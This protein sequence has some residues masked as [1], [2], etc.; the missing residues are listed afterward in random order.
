MTLKT[1]RY[2]DKFKKSVGINI[3]MDLRLEL[4][5]IR[6]RKC[7]IKKRITLFKQRRKGEKK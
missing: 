6:L 2:R 7:V 4:I 5:I 1:L 3:N